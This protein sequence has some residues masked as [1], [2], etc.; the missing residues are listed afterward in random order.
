MKE[1]VKIS[2]TERP[3]TA[4]K[5]TNSVKAFFPA[6]YHHIGQN[7]NACDAELILLIAMN[8]LDYFF[9]RDKML[10]ALEGW[11]MLR[12]PA[13]WMLSARRL[14]VFYSA[15]PSCRGSEGDVSRLMPGLAFVQVKLLMRSY[16]L[17]PI[18]QPI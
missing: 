17:E 9:D 11:R 18:S 5:M 4:K 15:G 12:L 2:P 8:L 10:K 16:S 6:F 7:H 14:Q 1:Y 13:A 3:K